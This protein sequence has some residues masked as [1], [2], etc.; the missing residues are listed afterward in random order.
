MALENT[1]K[2]IG[3]YRVLD[4]KLT[5]HWRL[6]TLSKTVH[7]VDFRTNTYNTFSFQKLGGE[8]VFIFSKWCYNFEKCQRRLTYNSGRAPCSFF[9]GQTPRWLRAEKLLKQK[10]S[11]HKQNPAR[12]TKLHLIVSQSLS[13]DTEIFLYRL[14]QES[15]NKILQTLNSTTMQ[16]QMQQPITR[17]DREANLQVLY[18]K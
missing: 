5:R 12:F 16:N 1:T 7:Q 14:W 8:I 9:H 10:C 11:L 15:P 13:K 4:P 18:R 2:L 3:I 6:V 17:L